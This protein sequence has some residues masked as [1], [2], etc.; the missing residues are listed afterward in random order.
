MV[1]SPKEADKMTVANDNREE[2]IGMQQQK[3]GEGCIL[4]RK[5]A[6][7]LSKSQNMLLGLYFAVFSAFTW[8]RFYQY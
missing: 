5:S 4:N 3:I 8:A 6:Q 1:F 7:C 2:E